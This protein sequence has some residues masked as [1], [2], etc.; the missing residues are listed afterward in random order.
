MSKELALRDPNAGG[1][2]AAQ[3]IRMS[4]EHQR[5]SPDNQR[6]A[7]ALYALERGFEVVETY[8]DSG[9]SG[10]SLS[11]RNELKRLL[12]DVL[13]G[14]ARY[15]AILVLDVSRWGRFQDTDQAAHYEYLCRSAGIPIHYCA[16][17]F[18][19]EG[20][21]V[22]SIVKHMKRV[23]AAEYSRELSG[24]ISRAQRHLAGFGFKQGGGQP[25]GLRRQVIDENGDPRF[26]LGWGEHKA[27]SSDRVIFTH[28]PERETRIV[29]AVFENFVRKRMLMG[30]IAKWL[31]EIGERQPNGNPWRTQ[32]VRTMLRNQL[33]IG[34]YV[35]GATK[36]NLGQKTRAPGAN[37]SR[38]RV[39]EPI[40]SEKLFTAAQRR[41]A[42]DPRRKWS[43]D[44]IKRGLL[45]LL[46]SEGRLSYDL[47]EVCPYLPR[48]STVAYRYGSL[49]K[50]FV[51][52][53]IAGSSR[54]KRNAAGE[55]YSDE[56]LLAELRR[57]YVERGYISRHA[58][59]M[60]E[61]SPSGRYY[62]R[63]FGGLLPAFQLAGFDVDASS[64]RYAAMVRRH[65]IAGAKGLPKQR[66]PMR[67]VSDT[68][69]MDGLRR[70]L[71][72]HGYLSTQLVDNDP[73][74]PSVGTI[75]RRFGGMQGLY[76]KLGYA[77]SFSEIIRAARVRCGLPLLAVPRVTK[78][79]RRPRRR[80]SQSNHGRSP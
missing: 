47:I 35:F 60:D 10:L 69:I 46:K 39:M 30:E 76:K 74:L 53:G 48:A 41:L 4:T 68:D 34:Y 43:D 23:M 15:E 22:A 21:T 18:D 66:P 38:V 67:G 37:V 1:I 25:Y 79:K 73:S 7:I 65:A 9:K 6:A 3:Y 80:L 12:G 26:I 45:R 11:G 70:L 28:G 24:K 78:Q 59:D 17:P 2:P 16:E 13:S 55:P 63:R 14:S 64:Q 75:S 29:A 36:S 72:E 50:A 77:E 56:E 42:Y 54:C 8:Q 27:L 32:P 61:N 31:N 19:S 33:Y 58:I 49:T 52:I 5:Y 57:I 40:V 51:E 44:E 71:N 62:I 20:G